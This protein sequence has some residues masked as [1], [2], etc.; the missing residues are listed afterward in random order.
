VRHNT[1]IHHISKH[2]TTSQQYKNRAASN[3]TDQSYLT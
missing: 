2:K 3:D 1:I